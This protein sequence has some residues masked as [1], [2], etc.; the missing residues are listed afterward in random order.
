[1]ESEA[2][3]KSLV[4]LTMQSQCCVISKTQIDEVQIDYFQLS[5]CLVGPQPHPPRF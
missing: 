3:S 4:N 1:M 5:V 2:I